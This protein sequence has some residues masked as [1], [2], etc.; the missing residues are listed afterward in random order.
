[1]APKHHIKQVILKKATSPKPKASGVPEPAFPPKAS[2]ASSSA[3]P[4]SRLDASEKMS[5]EVKEPKPNPLMK[6]YHHKKP[7]DPADV[8]SLYDCDTLVL[9]RVG[10]AEYLSDDEKTVLPFIG[11]YHGHGLWNRRPM[12]KSAELGGDNIGLAPDRTCFLWYCQL[13]DV[14]CLSSSPQSDK[15]LSEPS[16]D[17]S[18]TRTLAWCSCDLKSFWCPWNAE[19]V[20]SV[21]G[22]RTCYGF[23]VD[24][25]IDYVNVSLELQELKEQAQD[26]QDAQDAEEAKEV[27]AEEAQEPQDLEVEMEGDEP[28]TSAAADSPWATINPLPEPVFPGSF[29]PPPASPAPPGVPV[30]GCVP[31]AGFPATATRPLLKT[32]SKPHLVALAVAVKM[33][34]MARANYLIDLFLDCI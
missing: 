32:G 14:Y 12:W 9:G 28:S 15:S 19:A 31:K 21:L 4:S 29:P 2:S 25:M 20:S 17:W 13:Y 16:F 11:V 22:W 7:S 18:T 23:L 6:A 30:I 5:V 3:R 26:A 10:E 8:V 1:M 27:D 33:G 34:D 24:K